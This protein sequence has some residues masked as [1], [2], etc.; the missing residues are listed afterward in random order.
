MNVEA[1]E[2]AFGEPWARTKERLEAAGGADAT[3]KQLAD[4]LYPQFE[5]TVKNHGWW[6]QGAVIA[7]EQEI[8]RRIP[9]QR[10]DGA[11]AVSVSR[12]VAGERDEVIDR[13]AE[14]AAD[15][16]IHQVAI[17][18]A[19]RLSSTAKRSFWRADLENG[20]KVEVSAEPKDQEK[21]RLALQFATLP[22]PE[23]VEDWRT[24][25]KE[26]LDALG[27]A[28][29]GEQGEDRWPST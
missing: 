4:A 24:V 6:V 1:I 29:Y 14:L 22:S 16:T 26:L 10:A 21:V 18:G 15:G 23:A 25:G 7:F 27:G 9:G 12:T 2:R 8:G 5:K 19:P 3:H 17:D 13:F 20:V 28:G 11:F